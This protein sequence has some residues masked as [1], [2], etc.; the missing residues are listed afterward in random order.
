MSQRPC[1]ECL[2]KLRQLRIPSN[3]LCLHAKKWDVR[4]SAFRADDISATGRAESVTD[5]QIGEARNRCTREMDEYSAWRPEDKKPCRLRHWQR[6]PRCHC[7]QVT[8]LLNFPAQAV[9]GPGN[10]SAAQCCV[11]AAPRFQMKFG[12][13]PSTGIMLSMTPQK[14]CAGC[15]P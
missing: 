13:T 8:C 4:I 10:G 5:C 2:L 6:Q 3:T 15:R 7:L 9:Q 11:S 1:Q 12:G 14:K